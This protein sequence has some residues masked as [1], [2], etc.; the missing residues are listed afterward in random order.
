MAERI[1]NQ[2]VLLKRK[3]LW[4]RIFTPRLIFFFGLLVLALTAVFAYFYV[5]YSEMI[6]AKLQGTVFVRSTGIYTAPVKIKI[7]QTMKKPELIAYLEHIGY[8]GD[9]KA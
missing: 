9:D 4:R 3:S 2:R 8:L 1:D 6:D 5:I 7:G